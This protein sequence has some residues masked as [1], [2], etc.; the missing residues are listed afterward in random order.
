MIWSWVQ[1]ERESFTEVMLTD[2]IRLPRIEQEYVSVRGTQDKLMDRMN[3][4]SDRFDRLSQQVQANL[5]AIK[6]NRVDIME[7]RRMV[8]AIID[9]LQVPYKPTGFAPEK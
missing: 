8:Q 7:V 2:D 9:H 1:S 3:G 6:A 5:D 4:M